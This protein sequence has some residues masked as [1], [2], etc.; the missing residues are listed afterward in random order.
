MALLTVVPVGDREPGAEASR[1]APAWYPAV[2]VAL[3]VAAALL[4][5]AL[6]PLFRH[7]LGAL[8][9]GVLVV[10]SWAGVTG[11]MHWD[12][13]ADTADGLL[14]GH[15]RARRLEIMR[16]PRTGAFGVIVTVLVAMAAVFSVAVLGASGAY[17]CIALAPVLGRAAAS[18]GVWALPCAR[19]DGLGAAVGRAARASS[20]VGTTGISSAAPPAST[21]RSV[22][23][24]LG[25]AVTVV[26]VTVAALV[27]DPAPVVW[28]ALAAVGAGSSILLSARRRIGGMTGDV[29]GAALLG[30]ETAVL[31]A[32]AVHQVV[33]SGV[34]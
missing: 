5:W 31:V 27:G 34:S 15:E 8:L 16:D 25:A 13:L 24:A 20:A 23:V 32:A 28:G 30:S 10:A 33:T 18:V 17:A 22:D 26:A 3:G 7:E 4:A 29:L 19:D 11:L 14:G 9:G 6:A 12:A 1:R 21:G 2:G